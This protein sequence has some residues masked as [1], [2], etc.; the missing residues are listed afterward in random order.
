M[1]GIVL[2]YSGG[3]DTSVIMKWLVENYKVPVYAYVGNL[4]QNEDLEEIKERARVTGAKDVIVEN[5]AECF[6][7]DYVYSAIKANAIY[8]GYYL[9]GTSLARP[10]IAEGLVRAADHFAADAVSHGS[11][12]K[13]NDQVRFE[14]SVKA[15]SP[16][17]KI[18]APWRIWNF[19]GRKDLIE[20]AKKH[21]I[22]VPVTVEKPYSMDANL[23][24]ISY[25]GGILED[26]FAEP[27]SNMFRMT[28]NPEDAPNK[29]EYVEIQF[30]SGIP[31][32]LDGDKLPADTLLARLNLLG[33]RHGVGRV[34]IVEN[35]Y[36]GIKS[37]GVYESPGVTILMAAHRAV[38]SITLD[39]EVCH[40]KDS[41]A[42]KFAE[43][44]YN[45]YW[46]A[47][48]GKLLR[49][50]VDETQTNV[51]G[52][53]RL[54][55]YKGA[56]YIVGRKSPV[57]LYNPHIVS[58]ETAVADKNDATGFININSLRLVASHQQ[59][60]FTARAQKETARVTKKKHA[61]TS[62]K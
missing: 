22:K 21:K 41:L 59:Q 3:L 42:V 18:I 9:M 15:L 29:P 10:I 62:K 48:E 44:V 30:A 8:E 28:M 61:A 13:G 4:G 12:G 33:G 27:P 46:F 34:D 19:T 60:A 47:P 35:R 52:T 45:G 51:T 37:R 23:A 54:K 58:F 56:C 24:H 38:E 31:V 49:K 50:F 53:A 26:P 43:M 20:Y 6:V 39:R 16:K 17:L 40:L 57:S 7:S 32:A 11:T 2:A 14:F 55:L 25:E 1:K 36:I 5:L